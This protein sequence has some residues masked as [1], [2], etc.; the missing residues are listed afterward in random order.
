MHVPGFTLLRL[1][2]ITLTPEVALRRAIEEYVM[3]RPGLIRKHL[4]IASLDL[5][6]TRD[7]RYTRTSNLY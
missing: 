7:F 5:C 3:S 1:P 4:D 2:S 6:S